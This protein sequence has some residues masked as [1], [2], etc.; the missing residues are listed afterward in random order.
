MNISP[1]RVHYYAYNLLYLPLVGL[2]AG[3]YFCN[4]LRSEHVPWFI[5]CIAL[6]S[7][8]GLLL[9]YEMVKKQP[10]LLQG[11]IGMTMFLLGAALFYRQHNQHII[12]R[13]L[14]ASKTWNITGCIIEKNTTNATIFP[15][16]LRIRL[17]KIQDKETTLWF[18]QGIDVLCYCTHTKTEVS[19]KIYI[20]NVHFTKN[21]DNISGKNT[22]FDD[23]LCKEGF[24][25]TAF[26]SKCYIKKISSPFFSL[27]RWISNFRDHVFNSIAKKLSPRTQTLFD[28]IFLGIKD[29]SR[30]GDIQKKSAFWGISHFLARS[31]VHLIFV[32]FV[33]GFFLKLVPLPFSLKQ[34]IMIFLCFTYAIVTFPSVSFTRALIVFIAL[35]IA[36]LLNKQS[37]FLHLLSLTC[38]VLL[39][40]NPMQLFFLDFQLSFGLTFAL[41]WYADQKRT[42]PS[43]VNNPFIPSSPRTSYDVANKL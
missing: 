20:R 36:Q 32:I 24:A 22:S 35:K 38:I 2:I 28:V 43:N 23:Y 13:D 21:T 34:I 1:V 39:C 25:S 8:C 5:I 30:M 33:W 26:L 40:I 42:L 9:Y 31:G 19:D 16:K 14:F 11:T 10:Y 6:L 41:A 27:N 12:K 29:R 17:E 4:L 18:T 3:I 37:S 15:V 7:I